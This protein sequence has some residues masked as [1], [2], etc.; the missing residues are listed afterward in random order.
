MRLAVV[1]LIA[2]PL[3]AA[4]LTLKLLRET[5]DW[6][7]HE[8]SAGWLA[9]CL[10]VLCGLLLA[11]RVPSWFVPPAAGVLAGGV[12]GNAGSAIWN[13]LAVPN[14]IVLVGERSVIAFNLADVW[15]VVG[16]SLLL[17]SIGAWLV[18]NRHGLPEPH[19]VPAAVVR[20]LRRGR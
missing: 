15:V 2:L 19:A 16:L 7:H 5:P 11:V 4:D 20:S 17:G 14:P 6:A 10:V 9:L 13:G 1:I 3:A 12:L 18:R 8:R